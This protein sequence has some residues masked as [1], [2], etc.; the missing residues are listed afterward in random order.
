MA[1]RKS[2]P[3]SSFRRA[4]GARS[5]ARDAENLAP[6]GW[7]IGRCRLRRSSSFYNGVIRKPTQFV[8]DAQTSFVVTL[9]AA[10][11]DPMDRAPLEAHPELRVARPPPRGPLP[12]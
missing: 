12:P 7:I 5:H 8:S 10:D 9:S 1:T 4:A 11:A 3:P 2:L 6:F